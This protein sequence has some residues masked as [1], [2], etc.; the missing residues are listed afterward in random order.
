MS[1][2]PAIDESSLPSIFQVQWQANPDPNAL[3][4][5]RGNPPFTLTAIDWHQLS[6]RDTDFSPHSWS[7]LQ[8]LI[9]TDQ[10]EELKRW[11]SALKAYLAWTAHVK[12]K[13]GSVMKYLL[14]QRLLWDPIED[15]TGVLRFDVRNA[16]PFADA[17]DFKILRN[18]WGYAF[19]PGIRHIVVWLKQRLPVDKDG[20]LSQVGRGMVEVFVRTEFREKA[21]EGE[22]GSKII[23]FKN[24]TNLQSVR[25][26]EH[27][28]ILVRDVDERVLEKWLI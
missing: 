3:P 27:V 16:T 8:H 28:H 10:L 7:N 13:Y 17:E 5:L 1:R 2:D 18:D 24:T 19:E 6:L 26:L 23:W 20:A 21:G 22:E 15:E 12:E 4:F 9:F 11:P 14:D 25:S